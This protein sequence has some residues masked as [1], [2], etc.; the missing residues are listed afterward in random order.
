MARDRFVAVVLL[1]LCATPALAADAVQ[2]AREQVGKPVQQA[3]QLIR[4]KK[5][6]DA[7]ARLKEADAVPDK[8]PYET[9]VIAETRAAATAGSGDY[10]AAA[11]ALDAVLET[12]ILSP[13]EAA[14]RRLSIVEIEYRLQTYAK[15]IDDAQRYYKDGGTDPEP[16]R[17]MAQSYYLEN[18]FADAATALRDILAADAQAGRPADEAL[19]LSLAGSEFKLKNQ[20]GYIDAL[21]RLV[22]AQPKH[23]YWVDLCRAVQQRPGFA[24]R[25]RLD[26]DRLEATVGAWDK[27]EQYV[28]AAQL[29][30]EQGF[31]G[32]AKTFLD[33]GY[34]A[35]TLG[36]GSAAERQQ[37]L[38]AMAKQQSDEDQKGLAAQTHEAAASPT[39]VA[40]EKLGE[41]LASYG[42]YPDAITA[43]TDGLKKGGLKN[44]DDAKLH[45]GVAD[46]GARRLADA[47]AV[48]SSVNAGDGAKDLAKMW[49]IR[50]AGQ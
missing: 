48:L 50:M 39:G 15:A 7:L 32:D 19:L 8:S 33:K 18:D 31:P 46:F 13:P 34:A 30:L 12:H 11:K 4:Q 5:F 20:D 16:R 37:R 21:E 43:L 41:A 14:K 38:V 35:G 6:A 22:A 49:L 29:A 42:R 2:A 17:L 23:E 24:D 25:L 3:Q 45:L 47:K 26:L 1:G 36:K 27:P 44:S 9:Y 40:L 10:A 28:E